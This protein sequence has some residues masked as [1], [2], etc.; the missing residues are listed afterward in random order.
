MVVVIHHSPGRDRGKAGGEGRVALGARQPRAPQRETE[1]DLSDL[2]VSVP[3]GRSYGDS[4][5]WKVGRLYAVLARNVSNPVASIAKANEIPVSTV[6]RWV[7]EARRRGF[8]SAGL[9]GKRG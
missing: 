1:P 4:F 7:R 5:Y 6:Q 8:L 2:R 3:E 9:P